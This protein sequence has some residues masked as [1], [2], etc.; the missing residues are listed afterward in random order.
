MK[1]GVIRVCKGSLVV[2]KGNKVDGL[3]LLQGSV[4]IGSAAVSSSNDSDSDTTRLWHMR[5][6]HVSERG[7]TILSKRGLLCDQKTGSLDFCEHCVFGKQCRV[8]FSTGIHRT[9]GT[10][11]YIHSDLWGPSQVPSKGGAR[12]FVTFIEDFSRKVWV[13]FLKKKSDV[14]V[15]FKQW[16][17]VIENQTGKK[18]KR[19]RTNNGMEFCGSEFNKFCKYE[20]IVRHRTVSYTS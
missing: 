19:L 1:G 14:F 20:G 3:Y 15:T 17:V 10:V 7:M 8:K 9:S 13:Y 16:N 11:D 12:N 4:I 5:L 2:M 6:G 18:I